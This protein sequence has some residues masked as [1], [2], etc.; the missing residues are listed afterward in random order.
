M[1]CVKIFCV[2][3]FFI[4]GI[5]YNRIYANAGIIFY[6]LKNNIPVALLSRGCGQNNYNALGGRTWNWNDTKPFVATASACRKTGNFFEFECLMQHIVDLEEKYPEFVLDAKLEN[7]RT[8]YRTYCI[9]VESLNPKLL[10][11]LCGYTQF[12]LIKLTQ[13]YRIIDACQKK[14]AET[15]DISCRDFYGN[16]ISLEKSFVQGLI[17][18]KNSSNKSSKNV[19]EKIL[20]NF[21]IN[22]IDKNNENQI[23]NIREQNTSN[24]F[25]INNNKLLTT[26]NS[27]LLIHLN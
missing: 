7:S 23:S 5:C 18:G 9:L 25:I 12:T 6:T 17:C 20:K 22:I 21:G 13:L 10:S 24:K 26:F 11:H 1:K 8:T 3:S 4:I 15:H 16:T 14:Q 2:I 27:K 19:I